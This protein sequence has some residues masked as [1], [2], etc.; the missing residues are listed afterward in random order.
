MPIPS[1]LFLNKEKLNEQCISYA[2]I[3]RCEAEPIS[4]FLFIFDISL[5]AGGETVLH[6]SVSVLKKL[7]FCP[8]ILNVC[9]YFIQKLPSPTNCQSVGDIFLSL[10][11]IL[12]LNQEMHKVSCRSVCLAFLF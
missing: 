9:Q 6:S 5:G 7:I 12:L 10:L 2:L 3:F 4:L 8:H 11:R 1:N